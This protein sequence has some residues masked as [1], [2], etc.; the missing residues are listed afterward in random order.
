MKRIPPTVSHEAETI[1]ELKDPKEATRYLNASV[2]VAFEEND[3]EL[4]LLALYNVA[5][6]NGIRRTADAARMHRVSLNRMLTKGGN[7]EWKSLFKVLAAMHL[8]FHFAPP[9]KRA[10]AA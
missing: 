8:S 4:I 10:L 1:K 5:Q 2:H 3:P 7:P 6:A 9:P